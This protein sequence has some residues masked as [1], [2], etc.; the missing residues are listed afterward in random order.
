MKGKKGGILCRVVGILVIKQLACFPT[1]A[2]SNQSSEMIGSV[3]DDR[4]DLKNEDKARKL[5]SYVSRSIA[6]KGPT[7]D[8]KLASLEVTISN[9][10]AKVI[11]IKLCYT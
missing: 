10:E 6:E 9:Y 1:L 5:T 8:E 4:G 3:D 2:I 7:T 11:I